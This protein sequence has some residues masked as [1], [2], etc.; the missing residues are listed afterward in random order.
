MA[1]MIH[2]CCVC[3]RIKLTKDGEYSIVSHTAVNGYPTHLISHGYCPACAKEAMKEVDKI[4]AEEHC[5]RVNKILASS[6][7]S[8]FCF[9][10]VF[11]GVIYTLVF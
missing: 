7:M 2:K 10:F 5:D 1:K 3:G 6:L 9:A 11:N 8:D 4:Y